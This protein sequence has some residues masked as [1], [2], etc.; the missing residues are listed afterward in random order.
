[1]VRGIE[2]RSRRVYA[3]SLIGAM[4]PLRQ[5]LVPSFEAQMRFTGVVKAI[6]EIEPLADQQTA[7]PDFPQMTLQNQGNQ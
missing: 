4:L 1:M 3:P 7:Q 5:L 6:Q 2:R